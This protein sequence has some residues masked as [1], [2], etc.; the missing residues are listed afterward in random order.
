MVIKVTV[1]I[2]VDYLD[3]FQ[4]ILITSNVSNYYPISFDYM[5]WKSKTL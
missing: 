5:T 2:T 1:N 3:Y 4:C